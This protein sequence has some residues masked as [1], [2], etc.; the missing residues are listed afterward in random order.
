M[1]SHPRLST[2]DLYTYVRLQHFCFSLTLPLRPC[3]EF[4]CARNW[5]TATTV[6]TKVREQDKA[7]VQGYGDKDNDS[8]EKMGWFCWSASF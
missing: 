1:I 3:R 5:D 4:D 2:T 8:R 7:R 6:S